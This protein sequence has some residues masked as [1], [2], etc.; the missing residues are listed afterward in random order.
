MSKEC[1]LL[2]SVLSQQRF[3]A[4]DV[5]VLGTSQL[6]D[7]PCYSSRTDQ[8]YLENKI[9]YILDAWGRADPRD[10]KREREREE[11]DRE[12]PRERQTYCPL[13]PLFIYFFF[14]L[15]LP[16]VNWASQECSLFYLRS[17][18]WSSGLPLFYFS[19]LFP[20][21]QPPPFWTHFSYYNYLTVS[22]YWYTAP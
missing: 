18:L 22:M 8:F 19:G 20:V 11:R 5:K 17:S 9:K 16:S 21:F 1:N 4:T 15:C 10:T 7:S 3:E 14:P 13:A 2:S 12:P 6:S